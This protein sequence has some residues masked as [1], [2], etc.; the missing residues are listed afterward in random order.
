MRTFIGLTSILGTSILLT[1]CGGSP[2]AP[3]P[4]PPTTGVLTVHL[5]A[6]CAGVR[7]L[8]ADVFI[9]GQHVGIVSAG[10]AYTQTVS[11][12][13]HMVEGTAYFANGVQASHW[14]PQQVYVPAAGFDELFYC[15]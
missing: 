4:P 7:V 5:D 8:S 10:S 2:A 9:D 15:H 12:G 6:A 11:I 3:S 1:A 13:N 14:G